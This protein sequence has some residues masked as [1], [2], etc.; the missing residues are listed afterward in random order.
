MDDILILVDPSDTPVGTCGKMQA[1]QKGLLHRAFSSFI[2][3]TRGRL[4]LQRR[5]VSKYHSAGLW[6][7][8]CCGHPRPGEATTNA[9]RRRLDEE[10]GFDCELRRV[11]TFFYREPF[12]NG[13]IEHEFVHLH[14][15]RFNGS[16]FPDPAEVGAWKWIEISELLAWIGSDPEAFTV[17]FRKMILDV[18][19]AGLMTWVRGD[20]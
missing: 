4:L 20:L 5:A 7:N 13:L 2:F 9:A 10:M 6:S 16:I 1:H 12:S 19:E 14:V 8:T 17:W 18:G 3:D 15:G 11:G